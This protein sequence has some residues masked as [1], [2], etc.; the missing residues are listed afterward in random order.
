MKLF[1]KLNIWNQYF[2]KKEQL[3]LFFLLLGGLILRII[4]AAQTQL[5]RDEVYIFFSSKDN[6]FVNLLLQNHWDTAHPP[7]YFI[8]LHY[9]AKLGITPLFLRLPSLICSFFILYLIPV[10]AKELYKKTKY[11]PFLTLF[12]FSF[13][14]T[15]ISLNMVVRPYPPAILFMIASLICFFKLAFGKNKPTKKLIILFSALSFLAFFSD[16]STVWLLLGY[17]AYY[18]CLIFF[19]KKN[20]RDSSFLLNALLMASIFCL[21]W[22]PIMV[23]K[24][25]NS[26]SL[27][28]DL[29]ESF[30]GKNPLLANLWQIPF[31]IGT[32]EKDLVFRPDFLSKNIINLFLFFCIPVISTFLIRRDKEKSLLIFL[33][34]FLP[35]VSSFAVSLVLPPIFVARNLLITNIIY[36]LCLGIIFSQAGF[37]KKPILILFILCFWVINFFQA[38]PQIHYVDPSYNW[39]KITKILSYDEPKKTKILITKDRSF[40]FKPISFYEQFYPIK[41]LTLLSDIESR[42]LQIRQ[43]EIFFIDTEKK[44][45]KEY[46]YISKRLGCFPKEIKVDDYLFFA[47]CQYRKN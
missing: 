17:W 6:S 39:E 41:R 10:L 19:L 7:L 31:F 45:I 3:I 2:K 28:G 9:W 29:V 16:Y 21:L 23:L 20:K 13:S 47:K 5:W 40:M 11:L 27:E 43:Q 24:L 44:R 46:F 35:P 42:H 25:K 14:H 37:I 22:A 12:F 4:N 34:F 33:L 1:K 32:T 38:F 30:R 18:F 36:I 8:F 15:Q 26:F